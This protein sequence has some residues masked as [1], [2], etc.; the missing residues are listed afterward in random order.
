MPGQKNVRRRERKKIKY[1][2][3]KSQQKKNKFQK[4]SAY[5]LAN[6]AIELFETWQTQ[7]Q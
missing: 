6:Q 4:L 2:H 3:Q 7:H 5:L 1:N